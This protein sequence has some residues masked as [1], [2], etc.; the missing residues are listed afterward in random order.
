MKEKSVFLDLE[1]L[2]QRPMIR[3]L[4]MMIQMQ[5][6]ERL[7]AHIRVNKLLRESFS[8]PPLWLKNSHEEPIITQ[9]YCS[10]CARN[11]AALCC[12]LRLGSR[13]LKRAISSAPILLFHCLPFVP[14]AL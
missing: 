1:L 7:R 2:A 11:N 12:K 6:V 4:T 5:R 3:T 10:S 8:P 13:D 14:T 9:S